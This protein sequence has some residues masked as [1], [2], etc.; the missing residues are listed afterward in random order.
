MDLV[1]VLAAAKDEVLTASAAALGRAHLAHYERAGPEGSS[2]RL[3]DLYQLVVTCLSERR[4]EPMSEYAETVARERFS[5]GFDIAEVQTAFNVLEESIWKVVVPGTPP[6]ELA[7]P[8]GRI[9]TVLEAG[10]DSLAR[11]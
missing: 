3:A 11:A 1:A 10:K 6:A 9:G 4:L 5:A 7:E 8:T 2:Q